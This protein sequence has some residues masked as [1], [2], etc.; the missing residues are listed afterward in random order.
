MY[1]AK[2]N[3][4]SILINHYAC[5]KDAVVDYDVGVETLLRVCVSFLYQKQ[6]RK[7][8]HK[9]SFLRYK[10]LTWTGVKNMGSGM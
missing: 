3:I 4:N 5:Y 6:T 2:A 1:F 7:T 9:T 10:R 8:T